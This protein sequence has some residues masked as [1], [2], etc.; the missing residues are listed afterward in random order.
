[1]NIYEYHTNPESLD[2]YEERFTLVPKLAYEHAKSLGRRFPEGE[3]AIA[4][5][6]VWAY[7]YAKEVIKGRFP[8]GEA[9]INKD[10]WLADLYSRFLISQKNSPTSFNPKFVPAVVDPRNSQ[11]RHNLLF[12]F[13]FSLYPAPF[14]QVFLVL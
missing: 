8:E 4:K 5:N 13:P 10:K 12:S 6:K 9:A 1:M 3:P 7:F 14:Q 2:H 11:F